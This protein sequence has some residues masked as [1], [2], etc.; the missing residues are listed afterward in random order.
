MTKPWVPD[1]PSAPFLRVSMASSHADKIALFRARFSCRTD[2]WS[3][4]WESVR[5]GR[6]GFSTACGNEWR[7]GVCCKPEKS[8]SACR[9]RAWLPLSDNIVRW[10]LLGQTASGK[11]FALGGFPILPGDD[12]RFACLRIEEAFSHPSSGKSSSGE[13]AVLHAILRAASDLGA[14]ALV[15]SACDGHG[16]FLW[17]FFSDRVTAGVARSMVSSV[18]TAARRTDGTVPFSTWDCIFP[19]QATVPITGPG[20]PV[21]LPLQGVAR[22]RGLGL[23]LDPETRAPHS[24]PWTVLSETPFL[25]PREAE[26]ITDVAS[27]R[28]YPVAA[29]DRE[30]CRLPF[31]SRIGTSGTAVFRHRIRIILSDRLR[32]PLAGLSRDVTEALEET[33]AFLSP[34]F[35]D[36]ER[37][38]RPVRGIPRIESRV[39]RETTSDGVSCLSLPRGCLDAVKMALRHLGAMPQMR[40]ERV[41]GEALDLSFHGTLRPVQTEAAEAMMHHESGILEAGTAF[42]KTVLAAW[43]IARRGR[44]VL[45]L[46]NRRTLQRQWVVRLAQF[47]GLRERDI[48]CIGGGGAL[49]ETGRIDVALLQTLARRNASAL[50]KMHYGF[51][52]VDECHG[53]PAET[54]ERVVDTLRARYFLGLSATPVRRDGRHPVIAMQCGPVRHTVP[55]TAL[56]HADP[57][58]RVAIVR[59]TDYRPSNA[60]RGAVATQG[61]VSRTPSFS[62]LCTELCADEARNRLLVEDA[63]GCIEEGRSPVILT[64][65]R[66]HVS[67]LADALRNRG[68]PHVVELIGGLGRKTLAT[69]VAAMEAAPPGERR[70]VI[71]TGPLLGEGFDDARL[72]TLLL[73]TPFSW[74]GRLAQYAGR[75]HRS[76]EGKREVR[77]YDYVDLA[78]PMLARMFDRRCEAYGDIGYTIRMPISAI[79]GWPHDVTVP[80]DS[81]WNE[82]YAESVR[83]LCS[84]GADTTLAELFVRAAWTRP[85]DGIAERLRARSAAEAFLFQRLNTLPATCGKFRLNA[86]L[87]IPFHGAPSIEVDFL[88]RENRLVIELD[89]AQHLTEDA[90]RRD[91]EKD[92]ALQRHGWLVLRFLAADASAR[93][94]EVLDAILVSI[95]YSFSSR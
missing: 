2:V 32:I 44:S 59:P 58:A 77:V 63:L 48:G 93:L 4:R 69:A 87:P 16:V 90:Y 7:P 64:D 41:D 20:V 82:T 52:I 50:N 43:M 23:P 28:L 85:P 22:Q 68:V 55:A 12:C 5:T 75:L 8:C 71:A 74:R 53:L 34:V 95:S 66:D 13:D 70:V 72:D 10:H 92:I 40:D 14:P 35:D 37:M 73:A 26:R 42:G 31:C 46:V 47:L 57:F 19:E 49:R 15:T 65:R 94:G 86:T 88:C 17:W 81:A 6:T 45:V 76:H 60:L 33:A 3:R 91:R 25:S 61:V 21:P 51:V 30:R 38:R 18:L 67:V 79:P 62:A 78:V 24:D 9:N 80:V 83:R 36:A 29:V 84:D 56:A 27:E 1:S 54:F 89:G 39:R 11:P